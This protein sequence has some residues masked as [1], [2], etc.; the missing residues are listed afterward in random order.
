MWPHWEEQMKSSS[1]FQVHL[2]SADMRF[3]FKQKARG[4][5][6]TLASMVLSIIDPLSLSRLLLTHH[7]CVSPICSEIVTLLISSSL[8]MQP[9]LQ[10]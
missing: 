6:A 7:H 8:S 3:S 9:C 1:D 10:R 2:Y 4:R 5:Q